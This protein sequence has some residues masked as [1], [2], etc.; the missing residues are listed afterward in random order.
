MPFA[1]SATTLTPKLATNLGMRTREAA[2]A[3]ELCS[4]HKVVKVCYICKKV[5]TVNPRVRST[6]ERCPCQKERHR[7]RDSMCRGGFR[8]LSYG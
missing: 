6:T 4:D 8:A 5:R 7:D 2:L 1:H 3:F